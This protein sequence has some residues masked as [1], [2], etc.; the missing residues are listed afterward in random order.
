MRL[1]D[2]MPSQPVSRQI[3]ASAAPFFQEYRF[4]DLDAEKDAFL[5]LE[6]ILRF[7]NREELHWLFHFYG[8]EKIKAWVGEN[9]LRLLPYRRYNMWCTLLGLPRQ[10]KPKTGVDRAW[11]Y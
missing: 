10:E 3:P 8:E 11:P 4:S 2:L 9:G 1:A 7:G 6:R 5:V